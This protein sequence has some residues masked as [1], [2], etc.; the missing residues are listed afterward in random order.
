MSQIL[1]AAL[2]P[3]AAAAKLG[4]KPAKS[5]AVALLKAVIRIFMRKVVNANLILKAAPSAAAPA[6]KF[7]IKSAKN[8]DYAL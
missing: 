8:G 5:G 3:T 6:S 2:S 1:K 4:I 7:G